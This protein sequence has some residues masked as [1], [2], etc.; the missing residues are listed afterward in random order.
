[1]KLVENWRQAPQWLSVRGLTVLAALP[2][3]WASLPNDLRSSI[4]E[5]WEFFILTVIAI[6][7]LVGRLKDQNTGPAR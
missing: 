5:D 3:V 4:P 6:G 7:T 2:L 1:M